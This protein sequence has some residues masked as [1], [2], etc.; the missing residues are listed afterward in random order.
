MYSMFD[1]VKA[2]NGIY[3]FQN[4]ISYEK[5]LIDFINEVD[6]DERSYIRIPKW[7]TWSA[8]D[9]QETVYGQKKFIQ[10]D[11]VK[12][13][14]GDDKL[15]KKTLYIINSLMMAPEMCAVKFCQFN[16]I[17]QAEINLDLKHIALN[18]YDADQGMG[19]H[20][21]GQDGD[22]ILKYSMVTYLNDDY[23]GGEIHFKNQNVTIK[24]KAGSLVMFPSQEPYI[25]ESLPVKNGQKYMYTTHWM[26]KL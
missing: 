8:S 5:Q 19:P 10:T 13:S 6:L 11:S 3:Y 9:S 14:T 18:R 16:K 4:V 12:N 25:H 21:D 23:D 1:L 7:Q 15:D 20:Y 2:D 22:T 24:P 26:N 17:D